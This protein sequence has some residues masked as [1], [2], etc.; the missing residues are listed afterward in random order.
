[1]LWMSSQC[2]ILNLPTILSTSVYLPIPSVCPY[3]KELCI[4]NG[5]FWQIGTYN[6]TNE[7]KCWNKSITR[8]ER[9][10]LPLPKPVRPGRSWANMFCT[11][12]CYILTAAG[13][14]LEVSLSVRVDESLER[15]PELE[16]ERKDNW[17]TF[18]WDTN[19]PLGLHCTAVVAIYSQFSAFSLFRRGVIEQEFSP[20]TSQEQEEWGE[21]CW[22]HAVV[23]NERA[24]NAN[25]KVRQRTADEEWTAVS[26]CLLRDLFGTL[27]MK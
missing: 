1:M 20:S 25:E 14:A 16:L 21:R 18:C 8:R 26:F 17:G 24:G 5:A 22:W 11:I 2:N 3:R 6:G 19:I 27:F 23:N 4:W 7:P 10:V 13:G 12:K 15:E 9:S